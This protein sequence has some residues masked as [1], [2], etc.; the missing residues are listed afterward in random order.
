MCDK[1]IKFAY[2]CYYYVNTIRFV[3]Q[4]NDIEISNDGENNKES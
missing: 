1:E 4:S 2:Q 3:D